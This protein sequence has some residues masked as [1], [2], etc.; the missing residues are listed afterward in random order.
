MTV[1]KIWLTLGMAFLVGVTGVVSQESR[2]G[3]YKGLS[4]EMPL[5]QGKGRS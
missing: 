3:E 4:K 1:K 2:G 5:P